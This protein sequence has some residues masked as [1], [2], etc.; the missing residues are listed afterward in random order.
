MSNARKRLAKRE[1]DKE[2]CRNKIMA[3]DMILCAIMTLDSEWFPGK[4]ISPKDRRWLAGRLNR[5]WKRHAH[6][7][8]SDL[9]WASLIGHTLGD[10]SSSLA[11][12]RWETLTRKRLAA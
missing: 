4:E 10:G 3:Y 6:D 8:V 2:T 12:K 1:R 11:R 7:V 9:S 5:M